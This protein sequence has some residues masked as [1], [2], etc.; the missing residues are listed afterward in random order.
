MRMAGKLDYITPEGMKKIREEID[1]LWKVARP[2]VTRDVTAAAELGDRSENADYIYGKKRLREI[3]RRLRFLGKRVE[4]LKVV[5]PREHPERKVTF[6]CWVT[7]E[8]EDGGERKFRLVGPDEVDATAGNISIGSPVG[9]ALLGKFESDEVEVDRPR[10][11]ATFT[12]V[13]VAYAM[14]A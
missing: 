9:R 3:D 5:A 12:I 6:G 7:L 14:R 4:A 10:G 11:L 1:F 13:H 8:D 2:Q